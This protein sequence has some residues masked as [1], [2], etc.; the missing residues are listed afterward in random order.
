MSKK[1]DFVIKKNKLIQYVGKDV[2]IVIPDGV[3]SIA[4]S[5]FSCCTIRSL[6][7]PASV[8]S[9]GFAAFYAPKVGIPEHHVGAFGFYDLCDG[10][11]GL[12]RP[13]AVGGCIRA[14]GV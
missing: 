3:T 14:R 12:R 10:F 5:A 11:G 8:T 13:D 9:I 6:E 7:I 4:D 2:D 1:K